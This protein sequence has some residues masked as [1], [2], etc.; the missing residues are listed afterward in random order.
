MSESM[1]VRWDNA[2]D[3]KEET[4]P[5]RSLAMRLPSATIVDLEAFRRR[6]QASVRV[7]VHRS[8]DM[9]QGEVAIPSQ[10]EGPLMHLVDRLEDPQQ[11]TALSVLSRGR[12]GLVAII[13]DTL[14][15]F[16][17]QPFVRSARL[18]VDRD[19][20]GPEIVLKVVTDTRVDDG[21][22]Q[23]AEDAF[24]SWWRDAGYMKAAQHVLIA[25]W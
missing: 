9:I 23:A 8:E 5:H 13:S 10:I 7:T 15:Y 12:P 1:H 3:V 21:S 16:D 11:A 2:L 20:G 22:Y 24:W 19:Y 14:S 6:R 4:E 25:F 18:R 17:A